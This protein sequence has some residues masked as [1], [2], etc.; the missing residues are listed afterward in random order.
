MNC[1][2]SK[3]QPRSLDSSFAFPENWPHYKEKICIQIDKSKF[4]GGHNNLRA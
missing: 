2:F 1:Y 3:N 4:P